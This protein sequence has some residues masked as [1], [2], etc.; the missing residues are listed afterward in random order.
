MVNLY[1]YIQGVKNN[2][3]NVSGMI[4]GVKTNTFVF[5]KTLAYAPFCRWMVLRV[6]VFVFRHNTHR[7]VLFVLLCLQQVERVVTVSTKT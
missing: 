6:D 2:V 5:D 3:Y 7:L 1:I 4:E